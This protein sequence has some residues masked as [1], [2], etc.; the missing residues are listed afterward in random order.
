M[1][2]EG[3]EVEMPGAEVFKSDL[4]RIEGDP[5]SRGAT[6]ACLVM[7][8]AAREG[9]KEEEEEREGGEEEEE[10]GKAVEE[11]FVC[12]ANPMTVFLGEG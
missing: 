4:P 7:L 8:S 12:G 5:P 3:V 9:T 6:T 1:T 11:G 10:E 2:E